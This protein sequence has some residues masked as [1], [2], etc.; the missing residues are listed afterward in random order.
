MIKRLLILTV[1]S[2]TTISCVSSKLYKELEG[3]YTTLK[4]DYDTLNADSEGVL[5]DKNTLQNQFDQLQSDYDATLLERNQLQQDVTAL[6]KKYDTLNDAYTA[7]EQNS[8]IAIAD[9]VQKNRELLAQLEAKELALEAENDRLLKLEADMQERSQRIA[10]LEALIAS[11]DQAMLD[12]KNAISKALTAFEGKGLTVEQRDGKVYVSMEN[13]LLF[14]SGSWAV[15]TEGRVAIEQLGTVLEDN[16]DIVVLIEG[17]TD[18][19]PFSSRGQIANN[20]DLSTK[21]ATAIVQILSENT[22]INP[23]SL[24]AAG[25]GE[26]APIASNETTEGKSKNRRIEIVLTPKLD[27]ISKL[28]NN[29]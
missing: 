28:L 17:H 6:Q 9:N 20:W 5:N 19:D 4:N 26:F 1:L 12:L 22:A 7:L 15:G 11:K 8:S 3:K 25:R 2:F 24:T 27:E 18:N 21:R 23:K 14:K 16:P 29:D 10:E 13:K